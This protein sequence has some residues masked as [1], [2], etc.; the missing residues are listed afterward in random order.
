MIE[1]RPRYRDKDAAHLNLVHGG[2]L[3]SASAGSRLPDQAWRRPCERIEPDGLSASLEL[4][5]LERRWERLTTWLPLIGRQAFGRTVDGELRLVDDL[6]SAAPWMANAALLIGRQL[7]TQLWVGR[8]W[9]AFRP[10]LLVGPPGAGKSRF[11]GHV[12]RLAGAGDVR[13]NMAG[14]SDSRLIEGTARGWTG[15][16][17]CLPA[18]AMA[19]ARIA[20]PVILLEEVDKAGGSA[21]NGHPLQVLLNMLERHTASNW[22]DP[23]LLA[24]VD[25]GAVNWI[26][27]ANTLDG[28]SKPFL[29]RVDVV[30]TDGPMPWDFDD[31][32]TS[33][34]TDIA[35]QWGVPGAAL[36][37][38][39]PDVRACLYDMFLDDHSARALSRRAQD[40][41]ASVLSLVSRPLH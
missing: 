24:P 8:P 30:R 22:Y 9:L 20:N 19:Q 16:Q 10:L 7:E 35:E 21:R 1:D 39:H 15:A 3:V 34:L 37:E 26:M 11:A 32:M 23:C 41:M 2:V 14:V 25:I 29:S 4:P 12:A 40:A 27:T 6:R 33:V 28:L 13:V 38:I 17:P 31:L 5:G 18:V 36:P